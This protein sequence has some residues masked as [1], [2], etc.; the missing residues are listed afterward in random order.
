MDLNH[1]VPYKF[2]Y[3]EILEC[4]EKEWDAKSGIVREK[5]GA[6]KPNTNK[7][8]SNT[9]KNKSSTKNTVGRNNRKKNEK[10]ENSNKT[11]TKNTAKKTTK[12]TSNHRHICVELFLRELYKLDQQAIVHVVDGKFQNV[13]MENQD[14]PNR[15]SGNTGNFLEKVVHLL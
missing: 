14:D 1:V 5:S 2:I 7:K 4:L 12:K 3:E 13:K 8:N 6:K 11:Q 10:R 15:H 9:N